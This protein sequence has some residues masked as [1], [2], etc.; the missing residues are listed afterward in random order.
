MTPGYTIIIRAALVLG[1]VGIF[2]A[3]CSADGSMPNI[4]LITV[5]CLRADHLSCYGYPRKTTPALDKLAAEG[6]LFLNAF[7]QSSHTPTAMCSLLTGTSPVVHGV[8]AWGMPVNARLDTLPGVLRRQG[9]TTYFFIANTF[10]L[11]GLPGYSRTFDVCGEFSSAEEITEKILEQLQPGAGKPQFIWAHYMNVHRPYSPLPAEAGLFMHDAW[12]DANKNLPI[13][14]QVWDSYGIGGIP[15]NL[16]QECGHPEEQHNPDYYTALYDA[17]IVRVDRL[18]GRLAQQFAAPARRQTLLIVTADHGEMLGE[19]D[20]Y[21]HHGG[22]LF[23]PLL[24]VPLI[25]WGPMVPRRRCEFPVGPHIDIPAS[26]FALLRIPPPASFEGVDVLG[27]RAP[28]KR[29]LFADEGRFV[30]CVRDAAW[31]LLCRRDMHTP[32]V[33]YELYYLKDDPAESV[34]LVKRRPDVFARLREQLQRYW[35]RGSDTGRLES[36]NNLDAATQNALRAVG[37][38]Q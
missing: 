27:R 21:F 31:K 29:F 2:S 19:Q 4:V 25:F 10:F 13:V 20:L 33:E 35:Q 17:A 14:P 30:W 28:R 22:F 1:L 15:L 12:Y 11:S 34:N 32:A 26:I 7:A 18:I 37:Y 16:A 23:E 24:R 36:E 6:M 8:K 38:L 5:D 3:R 9:Y